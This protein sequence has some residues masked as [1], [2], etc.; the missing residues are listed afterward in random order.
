M[1]SGLIYAAIAGLL[2]SCVIGR[3]DSDHLRV[4]PLS[5]VGRM[6]VTPWH[7]EPETLNEVI[8]RVNGRTRK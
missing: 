7:P 6:D 8:D 5:E 1:K 3:L 4:I 2:S